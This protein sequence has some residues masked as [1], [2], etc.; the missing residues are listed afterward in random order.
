MR[1]G[2]P[3]QHVL[4]VLRFFSKTVWEHR[5]SY[6]LLVL[7]NTA[8][9]GLSPFVNIVLPKFIIDE[10]VGLKR[11][12]V[13]AKWVAL[14]AGANFA[15][16]I[17]NSI[18]DYLL[19]R[20]HFFFGR[21]LDE[22]LGQRCMEMD[23]EYTENA[24]MLN[25]LEKAKIGVSWYS[26]GIA[27][28]ANNLMN[29]VSSLIRLAGTLYILVLLSPW[30]ILW[31]IG[32]LIVMMLVNAKN[33]QYHVQFMKDLV[34]INRRF[35]YFFGLLK[36]F[37]FG[38]DIRL[39]DAT[40]MM[41]KRVNHYIE[42]DWGLQMKRTTV[43]NRFAVMQTFLN[44]LQQ[45][46]LFGYLGLRVLAGAITI[47]E[48]QMLI[49]TA[50]AFSDSLQTVLNQVLDI[51][52]NADFMYE[53][54]RFM[55]YPQAKV[56]GSEPLP[57]GVS[58]NL[59]LRGVSFKYPGSDTYALKDVSLRISEGQRLAVVGPNGGREDNFGETSYPP[60]RPRRGEILLNGHDIRQFPLEDYTRLFSVVFQ[61]FKLLSFSVR[62]NVDIG[63]GSDED[64]VRA[65]LRRA[66]LEE[67]VSG[68]KRDIDTPVYKSFDEEGIEF[69][70]GESQKLAIAR[71]IYRGS[72]IV[73]LDEPTAAL[74]PVAEYE[75]YRHFDR[76][77]GDRTAIY[78][79]HRLSS[80]R[81]CDRIA[82]FDEG[83]ILEYGTHDE[84]LAR[85]G[86]YRK[87]WDTQ[88]QWYVR[89]DAA[90]G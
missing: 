37:R 8:L 44:T 18:R 26:G 69:S 24:E 51:G 14:L 80:C 45:G 85:G 43:W 58:Y 61:D 41:M 72:P 35:S 5:P 1:Q 2:K 34:G 76:L 29:I 25:Q 54:V 27:G 63:D 3:L 20:A 87:M 28:L 90:A 33:Q 55:E 49:S 89:R 67:K 38:K 81:F 79:S 66:G 60:I 4:P 32:V 52:K 50:G 19:N 56:S 46:V 88:A 6:L 53:Y 30:L 48:F 83:R 57:T 40:D 77:V 22:L 15:V 17:L 36:D 39:Y 74:D 7:G 11:P 84:L 59:E 16:H 9:R 65:A 73:I 71:A 70:G 64:R 42:E 21:K 10:L 23:F 82:V 13:L 75:I 62:E 47:G 78:I 68:L 12:D 31:L 86:L